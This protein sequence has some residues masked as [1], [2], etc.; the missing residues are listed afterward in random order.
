[1]KEAA[2]PTVIASI[3]YS[4]SPPTLREVFYKVLSL[5]GIGEEE[6]KGR[7]LTFHSLRHTFSSL[8]RD[9]NISQ[10]DRMLVLGH[11]TRE[12]N[13]RYTHSSDEALRRVSEVSLALLKLSSAKSAEKG[14]E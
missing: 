1:M 3:V 13:D 12:V 9:R 6:R 4:A 7:N 2:A 8:S 10:E 11:K 14:A 5:A